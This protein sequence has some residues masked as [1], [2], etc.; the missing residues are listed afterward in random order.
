[1]AH[2][3]A[4]LATEL[5][6]MA[7]ADHRSSIRANSDDP[8]EQLAW[9]RLTARHGDRLS[10]IMDEYG[11][12]TAE[13]VGEEAAHAAWLIAQH[14]DRQLDVQRRAL[15]LMRQAVSEG[16][17]GPRELAFLRDRTLVNEGRE[18]VYGTQIAGVNDGSPVPWPC[19][20]PERMD[21]LRAEVGIEPFDE[22]VAKFAM[23]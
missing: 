23:A 5:A 1:M 8:A 6:D 17:A 22:Y 14:A 2:D 4:A 7:A 12:P 19:E 20:E 16:A 11:W 9:R 10:E 21:E 13:L 15:Q 18:Q 3:I